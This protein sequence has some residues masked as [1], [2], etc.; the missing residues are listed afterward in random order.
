MNKKQNSPKK[1]LVW[2]IYVPLFLFIAVVLAVG[3]LSVVSTQTDFTRTADWANVSV[4]LLSVPFLIT[5]FIFLALLVLLIYGQHKLI[6]WLPLQLKHLYALLL[7]ISA[8]VW[9]IS[10]KSVS[11]I[12]KVK[13]WSAALKRLFRRESREL[14]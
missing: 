12:I 13:S 11:P 4:V 9:R 14:R 3:V 5:S 6:K 7:T 1:E 10:D 8:S 2:Q